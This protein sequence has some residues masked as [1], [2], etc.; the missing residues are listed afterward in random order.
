MCFGMYRVSL[1]KKESLEKLF[2]MSDSPVLALRG[3]FPWPSYT[4]VD[5]EVVCRKYPHSAP[6][7]GTSY[8]VLFLQVGL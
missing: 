2:T 3:P 8:G 1:E 6:P 5:T 7:R 4:V